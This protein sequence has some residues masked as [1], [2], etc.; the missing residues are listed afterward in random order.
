MVGVVNFTH[1]LN[2]VS[3]RTKKR[4]VNLSFIVVDF[5]VLF[6][7]FKSKRRVDKCDF[8]ISMTAQRKEGYRVKSRKQVGHLVGHQATGCRSRSMF[9]RYSVMSALG[10]KPSVFR[11]LCLFLLTAANE[12]FITL[13]MSLDVSPMN[14]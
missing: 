7:L 13:A 5:K 9:F 10:G 2:P 8:L 6:T 1:W 4:I 14:R 3:E 12:I 11:I